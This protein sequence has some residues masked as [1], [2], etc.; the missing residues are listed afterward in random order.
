MKN[1]YPK[2]SEPLELKHH[3]LRNRVIMGSMH[4][5]FEDHPEGAEHL[6][7]FYRE[8]AKGG[9]ALIITGGISPN[10]EG[11]I[12]DEGAKLTDESEIPRHE[13]ITKAV[14][15]EGAKICMQILHTGRY[16]YGEK[17]VSASAIRSPITPATPRALTEDEVAR[18]VRDFGEAA[19]L[20]K[21]AG[22]DGVE[23]MGSEGYLI[24][25]FIAPRTNKREDSWGGSL[26]NRHRFPV[27]IVKE[28]RRR[29][30]DDFLIVFRLSVLDLVPEGSTWE[31][32]EVLIDKL[33]KAGVD[34]F[35]TGIGW[36]ESR[37]PTIA[38]PVPRGAFR[39]FSG[40]LKKRARIPVI[41]TN[42]INNPQTAE[43]ILESGLADAVCLARP[44]LA[45]AHWAKKSFDG[46]PME[47]FPCIACNQACLDHIFEGRLTSCL[48][49]PFA[50][51]ELMYE[52][53]P[54]SSQKRIAI[55]GSGPAA[56][57]LAFTLDARCHKAVIFERKDK[58][59]GQLNLAKMIPG[60]NEFIHLV[61]FYEKRLEKCPNVEVRLGHE[62]SVE[63]LKEFDEIVV[64]TGA[65]PRTIKFEGS[66]SPS[67]LSYEEAILH[68]ERAGTGVAIIGS[69]G[70][71]FDVAEIL[72]QNG[73]DTATDIDLFLDEHLV[74]RELVHR[75]GVFKEGMQTPPSKRKIWILQR[76]QGLVGR[77]LGKTT[78]WIHR[79]TLKAR[80]VE[81]IGGCEYLRFDDKGFLIRTGK[82]E[83]KREVLL[84]ATSVVVAA[85]QVANASILEMAQSIGIPCHII[86]GALDP[87]GL[88]AKKAIRQGVELGLKI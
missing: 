62:P 53:K 10:E 19:A 43:E 75:G 8:R 60:K 79:N 3:T 32:N 52:L 49:N 70:I 82:K 58:V 16:S 14:H 83:E 65:N 76:S 28:I 36:H 73:P 38:T 7:A 74:D 30:G 46:E 68:P 20:A 2:L 31:E 81:F 23:V 88:D 44:L 50:C 21:K 41:A 5:G 11:V 27:E 61:D 72:S 39:E 29:T 59:G 12:A 6:A 86:G 33:E 69:G 71:G 51:H 84:P 25:Q 26:E 78:G 56:I 55:V 48:V 37:V 24:N 1:D 77:N 66:D 13:I 9:V 15:E 22:Y 18:T 80:G 35:N 17:P 64:A 87:K 34:V 67:V 42:R 54:A 85:G 63:D 4:T 45:D 47:I 40:R 57:N